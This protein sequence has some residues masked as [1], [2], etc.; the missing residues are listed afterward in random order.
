[1]E[2]EAHKVLVYPRLEYNQMF[3]STH[4]S[5]DAM[6]SHTTFWK[7]PPLDNEPN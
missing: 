4:I 7:K 1:M 3:S 2:E 6:A 5:A